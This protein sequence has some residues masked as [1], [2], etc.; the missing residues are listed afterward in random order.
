MNTATLTGLIED[1][2]YAITGAN[3][4][5]D[6]LLHAIGE[7]SVVLIGEATHGTA[8]FYQTRAAITQRLI[9]EK[10]FTA[11][12]IEADFPDADRVNQYVRGY[13]TDAT[14]EQALGGFRRFPQWMWR[15]QQVTAFIDWLRAYNL[16]LPREYKRT[17]F[18]GLDLYSLH[19]SIDA[20][21][22]YLDQVDPTAAQRARYR[23]GCFDHHAEDPQAYG[24]ASALN[25]EA[26]CEREAIA[27]LIELQAQ[28]TRYLD[29]TDRHSADRLFAAEQNA[30]LVK[31]A[32][33]YYR[34]M[35]G[36]RVSTW[37]LRDRHMAET[38]NALRDHLS[39]QQQNTAKIVVW[40]HNAHLGDARATEM[41]RA[42]ELNLGQLAREEY[43]ASCYNI[44]FT[45][46]CGWVMAASAWGEPAQRQRVR[47][48]LEGSYECVFYDADMPNYFLDLRCDH[49]ATR[50]LRHPRL[51][52][53]IGVIY[54]PESERISHYF[55]ASLPRQFDT[56]IH[57]DETHAVDP[58][59][60][61]PDLNLSIH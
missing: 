9:E 30:R 31:N 54:R 8:E 27:Q 34:A 2:A 22:T 51:E 47:P 35:F 14:A 52:R 53:A 36:G 12:A 24:Y 57:F 6:P 15:N 13:G 46:Y 20:V 17:G 38:L 42:G 61:T 19:A 25:L 26:S 11:V 43:G 45:T 56:V 49:L 3:N 59:E 50:E 10:G 58:L 18:Y 39:T 48:A 16:A 1:H 7:A 41:G 28:S 44:G 60:A 55:H 5:L 21:I 37:N 23:Y 4:D 32:E 33:H 40:A 29:Q